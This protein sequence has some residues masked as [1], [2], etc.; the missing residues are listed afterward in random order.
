MELELIIFCEI[1][2]VFLLFKAATHRKIQFQLIAAQYSNAAKVYS[3][4]LYLFE[5]YQNG[6]K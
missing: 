4:Y 3:H 5:T 1:W 2:L 6:Y